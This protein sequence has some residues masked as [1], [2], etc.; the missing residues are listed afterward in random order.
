MLII[1]KLYKI[2]NFTYNKII[3]LLCV[4]NI[5]ENFSHNKQKFLE[6]YDEY[7]TIDEILSHF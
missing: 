5:F 6:T 4:I 7:E 2:I 3:G 1:N